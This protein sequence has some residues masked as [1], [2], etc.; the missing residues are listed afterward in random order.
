LDANGDT[1]AIAAAKGHLY[2]IHK[3]GKIWRYGFEEFTGY[4]V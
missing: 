2:Q 4:P 1:L 3:T